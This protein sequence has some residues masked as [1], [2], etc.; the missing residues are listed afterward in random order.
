MSRK[1]T[2]VDVLDKTLTS[3]EILAALLLQNASEAQVKKD[4]R[5]LGSGWSLVAVAQYLTGQAALDAFR[6]LPSDFIHNDLNKATM[7]AVIAAA[8]GFCANAV[9]S[10]PISNG[11]LVSEF[12]DTNTGAH[13]EQL[14]LI[15]GG[16]PKLNS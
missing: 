12:S 14:R 11:H 16:K 1:K 9:P 5:Q 7:G 13:I 4:L 2:D 15:L 10:G 3:I 6:S 8:H